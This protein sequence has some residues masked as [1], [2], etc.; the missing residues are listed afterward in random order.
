M[1]STG[2]RGRGATGSKNEMKTL[3]VAAGVIIEQEKILVALRKPNASHGLL[4]EFP[5]GKVEEEE[6]PR[7]ALQRE[8]KEE[9]DIE[10]E[11][12][13]IIETVFYRYPQYPIL[14]LAY[15]CRIKSGTPKLI[16]CIELLWVDIEG[17]KGL[18]M[19]PADDPIRDRL[20][21]SEGFHLLK[22]H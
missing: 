9:L 22:D 13:R 20:S 5:G 6:D 15:H 19:P 1:P 18:E 16:G 14:L 21:S 4:W 12:G 17:L 10:V 11:V 7:R 3:L 2:Q 8:L